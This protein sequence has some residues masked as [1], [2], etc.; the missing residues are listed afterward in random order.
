MITSSDVVFFFEMV[1]WF[2]GITF[3]YTER[4]GYIIMRTKT[5]TIDEAQA[6]WIDEQCIN[7]SKFVRNCIGESQCALCRQVNDD[8]SCDECRAAGR[9]IKR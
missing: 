3:I 1:I 9:C 5:I 6:K 2:G 8:V 7:L 4:K